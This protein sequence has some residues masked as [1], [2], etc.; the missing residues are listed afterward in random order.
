MKRIRLSIL[1]VVALLSLTLVAPAT[2]K[3]KRGGGPEFEPT[4]EQQAVHQLKRQIAA[5]ELAV[6]L[7]L[8]KAQRTALADV[9][10]DMIAERETRHAER[11][12]K[13]GQLEDLLEDYLAEVQKNGAVSEET[14]QALRA[15]KAEHKPDPEARRAMHSELKTQ[16]ESIL[17][18]EQREALQSFRPMSAVGP[19][20]AERA[21]R[22]ER[23]QE[24]A[25]RRGF[26]AEERMEKRQRKH[27]RRMVRDVLFSAEFLDVLTR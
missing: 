11:A 6:A 17:S 22:R 27:T 1:A 4:A 9:V 26:D 10:A 2:A 15:F 19:T 18:E 12:A 13:A 25:E 3:R 7:N 16:L 20:D 14:A 8:S 23:F 24:R 5:E 21:E